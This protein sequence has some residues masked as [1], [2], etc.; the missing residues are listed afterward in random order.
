MDDGPY[1]LILM[2][3]GAVNLEIVLDKSMTARAG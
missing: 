2:G 1:D 3:H